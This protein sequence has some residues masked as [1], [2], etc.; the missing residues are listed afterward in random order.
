M[1]STETSQNY[2]EDTVLSIL[3]DIRD[4]L[5]HQEGRIKRLE[6]DHAPALPESPQKFSKAEKSKPQDDEPSG[7]EEG[8][9][10]GELTQRVDDQ[11][12]ITLS[13]P[14]EHVDE[15][16]SIFSSGLPQPQS[17]LNPAPSNYNVDGSV[18]LNQPAEDQTDVRL[19]SPYHD[20]VASTSSSRLPQ[21]Q[22]NSGPPPSNEEDNK[23]GDSIQPPREIGMMPSIPSQHL[24]EVA[25]TSSH[26]SP[27]SQSNSGKQKMAITSAETQASEVCQ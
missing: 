23:K 22:S 7:S 21:P 13:H 2:N 9:E 27:Q 1:A 20:E 15:V 10:T 26:S 5:R 17:D 11:T 18:A 25:S 8:N 24:D 4:L 14:S 6:D 12:P 3:K 19:P 16:P